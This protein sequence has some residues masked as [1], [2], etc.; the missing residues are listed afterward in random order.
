MGEMDI[1]IVGEH[2]EMSADFLKCPEFVVHLDLYRTAFLS[3]GLAYRRN[4]GLLIRRKVSLRLHRYSIRSPF[5][6]VR[7]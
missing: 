4:C 1:Y 2:A 5:E 6:E 7:T 3:L